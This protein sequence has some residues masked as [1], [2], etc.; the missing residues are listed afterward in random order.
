MALPSQLYATDF[1]MV[2]RHN[3]DYEKKTETSVV[4]GPNINE[5]VAVEKSHQTLIELAN[6]ALQSHEQGK[7]T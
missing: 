6:V 7:S 1:A 5:N 2:Q 4:D 3:T